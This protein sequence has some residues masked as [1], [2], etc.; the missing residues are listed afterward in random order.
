MPER[1]GAPAE[2]KQAL[3]QALSIRGA[4]SQNTFGSTG[5]RLS[6]PIWD[7]SGWGLLNR[8]DDCFANVTVSADEG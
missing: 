7:S 6:E 2:A 4:L 8:C 5:R 1:G 3:V